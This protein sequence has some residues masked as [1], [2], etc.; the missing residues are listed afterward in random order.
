[1]EFLFVMVLFL[2][3]CVL[4]IIYYKRETK[5]GNV[6]VLEKK[7]QCN[8]RQLSSIALSNQSFPSD[9]AQ[10]VLVHKLIKIHSVPLQA[11]PHPNQQATQL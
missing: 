10:L 5:A 7:E 6:C 2:S 11:H 8:Q 3:L 1:M 4:F 9:C